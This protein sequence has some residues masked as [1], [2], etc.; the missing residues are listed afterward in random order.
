M[1]Y[2]VMVTS[3][4]NSEL[5]QAYDSLVM[6]SGTIKANE[7]IQNFYHELDYIGENPYHYAVYYEGE[8]SSMGVRRFIIGHYRVFYQVYPHKK[9]ILVFHVIHAA[10]DLTKFLHDID[11]DK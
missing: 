6:F 11:F 9:E 4:A 3:L 5:R 2:S 1:S 8:W 10:M 7:F